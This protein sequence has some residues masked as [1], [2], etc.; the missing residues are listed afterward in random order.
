MKGAIIG[1]I[2]GSVY[3]WDNIK[4]K[5]FP[6]FVEDGSFTDDTVCTVA[7]AHCIMDWGD[8]VAYLRRWGRRYPDAGYGGSFGR[9]LWAEEPEPYDS[10]GNGAAMRVSPCAWLAP[11]NREARSLARAVTRVTHNH[12][13]G[14]RGAQAVT[15]AIWLARRGA[16]CDTI[17]ARVSERYRYDLSPSVGDIRLGYSY[18]ITC[19]GTVPPAI[20][21]ALEANDFEDAIRNAVSIGGDSDTL[22]AISGS[23]A[24]AMFGIPDALWIKAAEYLPEDI[25]AVVARFE[26]SVVM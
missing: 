8:P 24:E 3:E 25:R 1:D 18:D 5:D 10:F 11:N 16:G 14:M 7:L 9:W 17:R 23:I 15:D 21:C 6:L 20:I 13:E 4:T 22:A 12:P 26:G 2:V 19:Q